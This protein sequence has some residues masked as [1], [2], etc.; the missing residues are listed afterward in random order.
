MK[1]NMRKVLCFYLICFEIWYRRLKQFVLLIPDSFIYIIS[2]GDAKHHIKHAIV[3]MLWLF[4]NISQK[5]S[6]RFARFFS[7]FFSA[8]VDIF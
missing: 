2:F 1:N 8:G 4:E 3:F 6:F 5:F 7:R